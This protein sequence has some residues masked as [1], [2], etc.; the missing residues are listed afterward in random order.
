MVTVK[1]CY[2]CRLRLA[3]PQRVPYHGSTA[4]D[5]AAC[6]CVFAAC[7][8]VGTS[9]SLSGEWGVKV[10]GGD[11]DGVFGPTCSGPIG[12]E[13]KVVQSINYK[14]YCSAPSAAAASVSIKY[15]LESINAMCKV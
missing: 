6:A 2:P 9:W 5:V 4:T 3:W 14:V 15:K 1:Y 12:G 7:L 10:A 13:H 11:A 8:A